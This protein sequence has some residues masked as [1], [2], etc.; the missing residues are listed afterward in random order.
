MKVL[1]G[2]GE[3]G[4]ARSLLGILPKSTSI[5]RN[6]NWRYNSDMFEWDDEKDKANRQKHDLSFDEAKLIFE[7][8][9]LTWVDDRFDYGEVRM[10]TVGLIRD[11]VA[12]TVVHTD[13]TGVVRIISAR[14]ANR[15]ERRLLH[16]HHRKAT[17][18]TRSENR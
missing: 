13:R 1:A 16:E 6:Y 12:V 2:E 5:V 9:T 15:R 3:N 17:S 18:G 10:T 11:V 14:L 8:P 4:Y 7:G